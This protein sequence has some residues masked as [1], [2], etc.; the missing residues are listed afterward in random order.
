M[1]LTHNRK[2]DESKTAVLAVNVGQPQALP[3]QKREVM[4]GIVKHPISSPVFL[5]FTGMTGDGQADLE[6]HGGPDK[7]VCVYDYSRY[8]ALEQLM[9]RKL[10]W[11]ACGENLTVEGCMEDEVRIGDVYELGEA[12]V[13]VSQPRQPCFKL[14]ARYDYK[15]LPVY[16]QESGHTGFYFR[17]LQEG[18]VTPSATFRQI[19]TDPASMTIL[20]AN[21]IMHQGKHDAVGMRALLAI[22]TLSDSWKQSLLKRLAKLEAAELD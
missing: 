16:F 17:V 6:H 7:A 9:D 11:G 8:P 1:T 3:G 18:E 2:P 10:D 19:S 15:E 22:S 21:R 5:S 14:G 20:E 4:S 12:K 13:Q